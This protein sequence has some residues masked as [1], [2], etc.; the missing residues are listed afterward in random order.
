MFLKKGEKL[1]LSCC[2]ILILINNK[3]KRVYN[4]F[5]FRIFCNFLEFTLQHISNSIR[6]SILILKIDKNDGVNG[7]SLER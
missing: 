1:D 2:K 6:L 7:E 4:K 5:F 3:F